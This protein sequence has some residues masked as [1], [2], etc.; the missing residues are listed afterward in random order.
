MPRPR[1][2]GRRCRRQ[3]HQ[4]QGLGDFPSP[5]SSSGCYPINEVFC[6]CSPR[7]SNGR[8]GRLRTRLIIRISAFIDRLMAGGPEERQMARRALANFEEGLAADIANAQHLR[9]ALQNRVD[10]GLV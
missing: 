7:L 2:P 10:D 6:D 4:L 1:L 3:P 8:E 5:R 9:E